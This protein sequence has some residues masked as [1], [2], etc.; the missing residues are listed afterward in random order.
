MPLPRI[1]LSRKSLAIAIGLLALAACLAITVLTLTR[2]G[3]PASLELDRMK[4]VSLFLIRYETQYGTLPPHISI[5]SNES[6]RPGSPDTDFRETVYRRPSEG[7]P[8]NLDYVLAYSQRRT[9]GDRI[10]IVRRGGQVELI[11]SGDLDRALAIPA[12]LPPDC[13]NR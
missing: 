3:E 5:D 8:D 4:E 10:A 6:K 7:A 11:H 13:A 9:R 2:L 12:Y 1:R